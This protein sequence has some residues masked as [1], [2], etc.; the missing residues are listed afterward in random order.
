M[1]KVSPTPKTKKEATAV[2]SG[3]KGNKMRVSPS[4]IRGVKSSNDKN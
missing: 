4:D 1:Q 2:Q 3:A